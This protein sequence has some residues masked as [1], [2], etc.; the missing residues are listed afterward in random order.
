VAFDF[1]GANLPR[2]A[3]ARRRV[4]RKLGSANF[5]ERAPFTW[6]MVICMAPNVS[7]G[8]TLP[9]ETVEEAGQRVI[10]RAGQGVGFII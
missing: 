1:T 6:A 7:C 10:G 9:R 5:R 2:L 4:L 3:L 8:S